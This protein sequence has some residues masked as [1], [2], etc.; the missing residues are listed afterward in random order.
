MTAAQFKQ[1]RLELRLT[2]SQL[3]AAMGKSKSSIVKYEAGDVKIQADTAIL[4]NLLRNKKP[5]ARM[6]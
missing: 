5:I 3:A 6:G 2:Q 1:L 4:I